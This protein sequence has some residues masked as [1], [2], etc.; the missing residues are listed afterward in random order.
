MKAGH[1]FIGGGRY[2]K[3]YFHTTPAGD[4]EGQFEET[5][6]RLARNFRMGRPEVGNQVGTIPKASSKSWDSSKV[7]SSFV[8]SQLV[9]HISDKEANGVVRYFWYLIDSDISHLSL[10][11][12]G[13]DITDEQV[14]MVRF[15]GLW[16]GFR[17]FPKSCPLFS[18]FSV[19]SFPSSQS[20][21][22]VLGVGSSAVIAFSQRS[23][24]ELDFPRGRDLPS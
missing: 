21:V 18:R 5:S 22:L 20:A 19:L 15:F 4:S 14:Y 9:Q 24:V 1:G 17:S 13:Q 12:N 23:K 8:T 7:C 2:F 3:K 11:F 16:F 10:S 6:P